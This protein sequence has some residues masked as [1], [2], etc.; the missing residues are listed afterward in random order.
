MLHRVR[1]H[2]ITL[3]TRRTTNGVA[4]FRTTKS[5][6][7]NGV[8]VGGAGSFGR[9]L[10]PH[11][12]KALAGGGKKPGRRGTINRRRYRERRAS[13][14]RRRGRR[15]KRH[16]RRVILDGAAW[17]EKWSLL[18]TEASPFDFWFQ[19]TGRGMGG[20]TSPKLLSARAPGFDAVGVPGA[21]I[22]F[23]KAS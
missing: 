22:L 19:R 1:A 8:M 9:S 12:L 14:T 4:P 2:N 16:T 21:A 15:W 18:G 5:G 23:R 13:T 17:L 20:N 10:R 3:N 6:P 11:T 7:A